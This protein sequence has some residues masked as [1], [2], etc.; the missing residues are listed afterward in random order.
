MVNITSA[1]RICLLLKGFNFSLKNQAIKETIIS[2]MI[3][4]N[5]IAQ[6]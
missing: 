1:I 3:M 4:K 2:D 6:S 5:N